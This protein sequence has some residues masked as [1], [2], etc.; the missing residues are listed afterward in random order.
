VAGIVTRLGWCYVNEPYR[1]VEI[2]SHQGAFLWRF[3]YVD[4]DVAAGDVVGSGQVIGHAQ[5]IAAKYGGGM[6]NHVHVEVN[7]DPTLLIGGQY[8]TA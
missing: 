7:I 2:L 4:P 1:L 3:L 5:D 6:I 8:G